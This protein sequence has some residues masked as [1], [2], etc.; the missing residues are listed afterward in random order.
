M[1]FNLLHSILILRDAVKNF[2]KF[3]VQGLKANRKQIKE[4][5]DNSLMLVTALSPILGYDQCAKIAHYAFVKDLSLRQACIKLG[6]LTGPAFDKVVIPE[7][8][9]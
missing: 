2:T 9:T 4:Y 6:F 1:I 3:C 7:K 5:V 8:M